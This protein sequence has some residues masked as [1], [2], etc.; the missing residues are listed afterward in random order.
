MYENC[1]LDPIHVGRTWIRLSKKVRPRIRNRVFLQI[2]L[3]IPD[4]E[5]LALKLSNDQLGN[6]GRRFW[7]DP[8][9]FGPPD[10]LLFFHRSG[11]YL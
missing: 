11:S 10:S 3:F 8:L 2:R 6:A 7:S 9:I 1:A 5:L 4:K